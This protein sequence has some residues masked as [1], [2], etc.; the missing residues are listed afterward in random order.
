MLSDPTRSADSAFKR[1]LGL[2]TKFRSPALAVQVEAIGEFPKLLDQ[3]P[4]P[5]LV[6]SAFLKLGDLFRTSP[7]AL[8]YH[9]AQVFASSRHHLA[10]IT[11][12]EELLKRMLVVLY[13]NDSTA[14]VLALRLLGNASSIFAHFPEAQHGILLRYQS[15]H[16]L[17]IAAAV[18]ATEALLKYSPGFLEVVWE[19]V[20]G[21]ANDASVPDSVRVRLIHSLRHAAPRLQL[22]SLLYARCQSWVYQPSNTIALRSAA[23]DT[24][25]SV[26]QTHNELQP[27]DAERISS[28]VLHDLASARHA[29]LTLIGRWRPTEQMLASHPDCAAKVSSRLNSRVETLLQE[30]ALD[31]ADIEELR[32]AILSQD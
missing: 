15:S 1:L 32:L 18:Q 27:D 20:L 14:R 30:D 28:L 23:M 16:P 26:L 8:R 11:Q 29:A 13:S 12:T 3:F 17:E 7:N 2:D 21:K 19:T 10:Q 4:F 24:W 31:H 5:S 6:N 22:S 25:R 9:I